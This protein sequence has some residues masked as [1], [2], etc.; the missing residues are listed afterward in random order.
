MTGKRDSKKVLLKF[1]L[2]R[3]ENTTK[4]KYKVA[5]GY[6]AIKAADKIV[7]PQY[8]KGQRPKFQIPSAIKTQISLTLFCFWADWALFSRAKKY[9][10]E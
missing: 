5:E 6:K 8:V 9:K 10:L 1:L 3:A 2:T 7:L 4:Y